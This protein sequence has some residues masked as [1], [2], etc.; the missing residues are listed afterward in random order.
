MSKP[1]ES[2]GT[3]GVELWIGGKRQR[4][5][6]S[7]QGDVTNP[8]TGKVVRRVPL[9]NAADI[10]AAVKAATSAFPGWRGSSPEGDSR[11][12]AFCLCVRTCWV[13]DRCHP[14]CQ[15]QA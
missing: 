6:A 3:A 5:T 8:A 12:C 10:D 9:C 14:E 15:R 11:G 4:A 1:A 2:G 13:A 7:R